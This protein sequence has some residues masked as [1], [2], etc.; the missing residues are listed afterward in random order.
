[1]K[2]KYKDWLNLYYLSYYRFSNQFESIIICISNKKRTKYS[3][4]FLQMCEEWKNLA[5]PVW[6][7]SVSVYMIIMLGKRRNSL[8]IDQMQQMPSQLP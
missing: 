2:Q 3:G 4:K 1:M 5:M 7:V 6:K 8:S